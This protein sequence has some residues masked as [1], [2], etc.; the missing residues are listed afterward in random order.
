MTWTDVVR[1]GA[2]EVIIESW[3]YIEGRVFPHFEPF[4]NKRNLKFKIHRFDDGDAYLEYP[5]NTFYLRES[6]IDLHYELREDGKIYVDDPE[7]RS[8]IDY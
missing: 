4:K 7:I 8:D 2:T 1:S 5:N 6:E 3:G